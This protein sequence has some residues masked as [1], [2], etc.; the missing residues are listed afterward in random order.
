MQVLLTFPM[1]A[2]FFP[3]DAVASIMDGS[4]MVRIGL[5]AYKFRQREWSVWE[6]T[7]SYKRICTGLLAPVRPN[8][9]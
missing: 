5:A 4:L 6:L 7:P 2:A 1:V 3:I 8:M 9:M